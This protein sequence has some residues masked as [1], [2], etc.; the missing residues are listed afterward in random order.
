MR[1]VNA[2]DADAD[3][4][5]GTRAKAKARAGAA[6][7]P[8]RPDP[9]LVLASSLCVIILKRQRPSLQKYVRRTIAAALET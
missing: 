7:L 8:Y 2:A 9:H 1:N 3:A 4:A 6:R 5:A